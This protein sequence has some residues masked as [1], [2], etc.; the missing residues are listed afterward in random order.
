MYDCDCVHVNTCAHV[1]HDHVIMIRYAELNDPEEQRRRFSAQAKDAS[2]GDVESHG[3]DEE[4]CKAL[5]VG[6][7]PTGGWGMGIDRLVSLL[8]GSSHIRVRCTRQHAFAGAAYALLP[9]CT[10]EY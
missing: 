1:R 2:A 10:C 3:P 9:V 4:F 8:T 7:P 6:L 5:E